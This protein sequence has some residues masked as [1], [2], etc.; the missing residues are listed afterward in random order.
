MKSKTRTQL[1]RLV[2]ELSKEEIKEKTREAVKLKSKVVDE[3]RGLL[4]QYKVLAIATID[5]TPAAEARRIYGKLAGYGVV[6]L[7][8]NSLVLKAM[9]DRG[10]RNLEEVSK[11]LSGSNIF[12]FTNM[13]PFKLAKLL[14][15]FVEY[16]YAKP[17]DV[18]SFDVELAPSPTGV[19]PGPSMSLFG[20]LKIPTQVREGIIW[21]AKDIKVLK[22]G[23][24]ISPELSSLLRRLGIPVIPVKI[25]LKAVF[26]DSRVYLPK[27]LKIDYEVVKKELSSAVSMSKLLALEL[28]LPAPEVLPDLLIRAHKISVELAAAARYVTPETARE[29]LIKAASQALSVAQAISG[30]VDLGISVSTVRQEPRGKE[31]VGKEEAREEKEEVAEEDIAEGISSLFG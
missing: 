14:D 13:N 25:Q 22:Q 2:S 23:D 27:D 15:D 7:Y 18:V 24:K 30:K 16:R 11:Y 5:R 6:K 8:K 9:R 28:A 17:G 4:D 29:L 26:E 1:R 12:I 31:E 3:I 10:I 20:K 21:I 19:K